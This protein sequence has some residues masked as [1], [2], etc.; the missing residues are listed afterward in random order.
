MLNCLPRYKYISN[1]LRYQQALSCAT[2]SRNSTGQNSLGRAW[3]AA[4]AG[5]L[6][7]TGS[8]DNK[9]GGSKSNVSKQDDSISS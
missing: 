5:V 2:D 9:S 4:T 6:Q 1:D 7:G 8:A 3:A